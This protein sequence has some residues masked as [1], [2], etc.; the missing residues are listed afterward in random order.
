MMQWQTVTLNYYREF[1]RRGQ[2]TDGV[3]VCPGNVLFKEKV[4]P[5]EWQQDYSDSFREARAEELADGYSF[6]WHLDTIS[7]FTPARIKY[8]LQSL[9]SRNA[10]IRQDTAFSSLE[11][12]VRHFPKHDLWVACPG[13]GARKLIPDEKMFGVRG[14]LVEVAVPKEIAEKIPGFV[15]DAPEIG[16]LP[17]P[18]DEFTYLVKSIIYEDGR[19]SLILGGTCHRVPDEET[20]SP[21]QPDVRTR[22]AI[23]SRCAT[24]LHRYGVSKEIESAEFIKDRI[25]LRPSRDG[26][27]RFEWVEVEGKGILLH[28]GHGGDG[29]SIS[30][31]S[32]LD[33]A[34]QV[35]RKLSC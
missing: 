14:Q 28:Y 5:P 1:L 26:G 21:Q 29:V 9:R 17:A 25:G 8:L 15:L 33:A 24:L 35:R 19:R 18:P 16:G 23:W 20:D 22:E 3:A 34:E 12:A 31:G 13:L 4:P 10:V 32:A 11:S 30:K 7:I 6:G 2:E 27:P